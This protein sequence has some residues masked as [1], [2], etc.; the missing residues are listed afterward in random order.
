MDQPSAKLQIVQQTTLYPVNNTPHGKI[1]V[2]C[3][4][5]TCQK[6]ENEIE[7]LKNEI[8]KEKKSSAERAERREKADAETRA[9]NRTVLTTTLGILLFGM[10]CNYFELTPKLMSLFETRTQ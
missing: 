9:H 5:N 3:S 6:D 10:L 1:Y 2:K 7:S 8:E 4:N